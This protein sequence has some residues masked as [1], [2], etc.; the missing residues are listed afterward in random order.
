MK[1]VH[2]GAMYHGYRNQPHFGKVNHE[3]K[4]RP[5]NKTESFYHKMLLINNLTLSFPRGSRGHGVL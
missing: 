4:Y 1:D 2:A 5:N 3:K